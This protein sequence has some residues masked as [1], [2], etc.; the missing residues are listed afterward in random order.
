MIEEVLTAAD[1]AER[2]HL[3]PARVKQLIHHGHF[4]GAFRSSEGRKSQWLIPETEFDAYVEKR[5]EEARR[6][7]NLERTG[8]AIASQMLRS[9]GKVKSRKAAGATP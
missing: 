6:E 4:P 9:L 3:T 7:L 5:K 2:L 1:V 8:Q